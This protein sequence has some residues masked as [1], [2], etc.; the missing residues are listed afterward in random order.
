MLFLRGAKISE[1]RLMLDVACAREGFKNRDINNIGF[2]RSEN[3]LA[4][5]FTKHMSQAILLKTIQ[6]GKLQ[7][8]VDQ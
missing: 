6:A 2:I 8:K 1:K 7:V 5:G 3:K 4:D